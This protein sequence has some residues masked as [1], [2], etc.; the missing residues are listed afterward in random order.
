MNEEMLLAIALPFFLT[1][2]VLEYVFLKKR[3][4]VV[5]HTLKDTLASLTMGVGFLGW[6]FLVKGFTV[7]A[8]AF[9]YEFRVV[10]MGDS[11]LSY[12]VLFIALDFFYYWYHRTHHEIRILWAAHVNHHSSQHYNLS[13]ALRQSWSSVFSHWIFMLPLAAAGWRPD[14]ILLMG[15][16]NLVYQYWIHTEAVDKMGWLEWIL[17]TPSHHRVHHGSNAHYLDK[18]YGGLLII[19]DRMFGT[20]QEEDVPVSY[21]LTK[22]IESYNP[23]VIAYHEHAAILKDLWFAKTFRDGVRA[24]FAS[25]ASLAEE[26][27]KYRDTNSHGVNAASQRQSSP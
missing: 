3:P 25:P 15:L 26:P 27:I 6:D 11:F 24:F 2:V 20:F 14:Q 22:N 12:A 18:N 1:T 4:N 8:Y 9:A 5:G 21:G 10:E 23:I 7:A 13:T 16:L 17:M 19:W